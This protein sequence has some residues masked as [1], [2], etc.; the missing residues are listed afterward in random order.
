MQCNS[1]YTSG[2][3]LYGVSSISS[4]CNAEY[5]NVLCWLNR[6]CGLRVFIGFISFIGVVVS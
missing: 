5:V 2:H 6:F 4:P 3:K 1:V